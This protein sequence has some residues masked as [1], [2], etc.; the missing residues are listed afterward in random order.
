M[1]LVSGFC[2]VQTVTTTLKIT[3]SKKNVKICQVLS[4]ND[5]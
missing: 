1:A 4:F 5:K 3:N 2:S